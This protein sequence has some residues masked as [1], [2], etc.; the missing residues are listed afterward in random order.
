M[1]IFE[2]LKFSISVSISQYGIPQQIMSNASSL[3]MTHLAGR[4]PR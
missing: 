3:Y 4:K 1:N 2:L